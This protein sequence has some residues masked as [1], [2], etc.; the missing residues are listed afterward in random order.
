VEQFHE[1][2][3]GASNTTG[4]ASFAMSSSL[5]TPTL[6][7]IDGWK[8]NDLY[9]IGVYTLPKELREEGVQPPSDRP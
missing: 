6:P 7:E 1:T 9:E 4:H 5:A 2:S 8:N 3:I